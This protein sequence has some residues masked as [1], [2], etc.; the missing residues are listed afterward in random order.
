[1]LV[2][3]FI[4]VFVMPIAGRLVLL[5]ARVGR[6]VGLVCHGIDES[7][8]RA[9]LLDRGIRIRFAQGAPGSASRARPSRYG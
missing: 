3:W 8:R 2:C 6:S 4:G 7:M 9:H 1:M 5:V